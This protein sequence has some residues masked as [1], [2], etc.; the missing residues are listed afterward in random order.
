MT[1]THKRGSRNVRYS[2]RRHLFLFLFLLPILLLL[3]AFLVRQFAPTQNTTA[4][5]FDAIIV[6]GTPAD[7]DGNPTPTQLSRVTEA[8]Q[9]YQR[10]VAPRLILTGGA[11]HNQFVEAE[12]MARIA[13]SQGIPA[14]ALF[15]EPK[16]RDTMQNACYSALIMRLHGWRSAEIISNQ[17]HLPRAGLI[18]NSLPLSWRT[19][20]APPLTPEASAIESVAHPVEVLKTLH[21]LL[22]SRW[23]EQCNLEGPAS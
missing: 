19:H 20:A 16:A 11:A 6:L 17:S 1:I 22:L 10:G 9:E 15:I 4:T 7:D 12:V 8:V 13:Q 3:W 18:F 21:Y 2:H 23:S 5:H 14:S